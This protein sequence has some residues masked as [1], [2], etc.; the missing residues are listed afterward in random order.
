MK[1]IGFMNWYDKIAAFYDPFTAWLYRKARLTLIES[2]EMKQGDRV[3]VLACGTGQSFKLI[4]GKIGRAG[5]IIAIDY[6]AGMLNVAQKRIKKNNWQNIRLIQLDARYLSIE[7]LQSRGISPYFDVVIAELAFSVIP[8]WKKVMKTA[9]S[10]LKKEG[11]FGLL[12]W[13]RDKRDWLTKIVD[14]LAKA[15][16]TRNTLGYAQQV[17]EEFI[18]VKKFL[19]NNVYVGIGKSG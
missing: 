1:K 3:L 10:L 19:L 13:Y 2:L 18:V 15:E 14:F 6:S 5:E 16:T 9:A 12:D 17:F 8:E 11:R 7:S 4:E